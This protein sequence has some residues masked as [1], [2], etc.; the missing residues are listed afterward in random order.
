M[1]HVGREVRGTDEAVERALGTNPLPIIVV[2]LVDIIDTY[3]YTQENRPGR[4]T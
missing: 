2:S 3:D 4:N 1:E